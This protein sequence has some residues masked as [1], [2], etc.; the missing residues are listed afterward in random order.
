MNNCFAFILK[1]T[2][3]TMDYFFKVT[4]FSVFLDIATKALLCFAFTTN[5]PKLIST[6]RTEGAL[7]CL[8]GIR[9]L[10]I[11]YIILGHSYA[12][13]YIVFVQS[14]VYFSLSLI[15]STLPLSFHFILCF[16]IY[17]NLYS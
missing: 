4:I 12:V 14:K 2:L 5:F 6:K 7:S 13:K 10:T 1:K 16:S 17:Y 8:D 9:V 11:F 15:P 3:Q